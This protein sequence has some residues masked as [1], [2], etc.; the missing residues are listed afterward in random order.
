[1][2]VPNP[3]QNNQAANKGYV[4]NLLSK[5]IENETIA[6]F[7]LGTK[8]VYMKYLN[9]SITVGNG[10]DIIVAIP[11]LPNIDKLVSHSL[12]VDNQYILPWNEGSVN[13]RL[14][15]QNNILKIKS[16][17]GS[18]VNRINGMVYYTKP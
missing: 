6:P 5:N 1:M 11:G 9:D 10:N 3:T 13:L 15:I 14:V 18:W 16:N 12:T 4:D 7:K 17:N 2:V 8:T